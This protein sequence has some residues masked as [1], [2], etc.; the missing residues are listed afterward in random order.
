M[1][2][3]KSAKT[4]NTNDAKYSCKNFLL[5]DSLTYLR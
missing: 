1:E 2:Y 4:D 3:L 5:Y